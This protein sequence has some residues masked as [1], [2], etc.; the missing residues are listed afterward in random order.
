[1]LGGVCAA[2][3]PES[4]FPNKVGI[5]EISFRFNL[6]RVAPDNSTN[7]RSQVPPVTPDRPFPIEAKVHA[8][9]VGL[10]VVAGLDLKKRTKRVS[11]I[12]NYLAERNFDLGVYRA[13]EFFPA[14][15]RIFPG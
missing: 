4:A 15:P 10:G 13:I 5:V 8:V 14:C 11:A 6:G 3:E 1:M 9:R 2:H 12:V 7:R